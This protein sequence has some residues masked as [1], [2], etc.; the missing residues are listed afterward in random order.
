MMSPHMKFV[1][2]TPSKIQLGIRSISSVVT[3]LAIQ[4]RYGMD[5]TIDSRTNVPFMSRTSFGLNPHYLSLFP[6]FGIL[7]RLEPA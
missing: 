5:N 1:A 7:V 6:T 2:I 4:T 3:I